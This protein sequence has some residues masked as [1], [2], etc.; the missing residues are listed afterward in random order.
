MIGE[1]SVIFVKGIVI[2][3][4][5]MFYKYLFFI[6]NLKNSGIDVYGLICR[7]CLISIYFGFI[8]YY[9]EVYVVFIF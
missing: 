6:W 3:S 2:S 7:S 8:K 5:F 1:F 4:V 9:L